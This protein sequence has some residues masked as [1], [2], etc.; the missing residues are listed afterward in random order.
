M[1]WESFSIFFDNYE[2]VYKAFR[3][4]HSCTHDYLLDKRRVRAEA[5]THPAPI[6]QGEE[7]KP[8]TI[9]IGLVCASGKYILLAADTRGSY[10][11]VTS[12][13]QMAKTFDLPANYCG[14]IAGAGDYCADVIAELYHRMSQ[15]P[16]PEIAHEGVR[17]CIRDS[18]HT[19]FMERAEEAML[20]GPKITL[21]QYYHDQ[22]LLPAIRDEA[23]RAIR[24]LEIEGAL[25]VAGFYNGQPVQFI[26][27]PKYPET[28]ALSIRSEITPGN[29][30][31][32][33]GASAATFWLNY[34][35]QNIHLGLAHSLLHLTEAKQFAET[36]QTVGSMRQTI[37]LWPGGH[38]ALNWAPE[39]QSLVQCW[40]HKYGL[41]LSD[42][43]EDESCNKAVRELFAL[44]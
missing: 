20:G 23:E 19:V 17:R 43:L 11:N 2:S 22:N 41:P 34:R 6:T 27:E 29:A 12:N 16:G 39:Y 24:S 40:W 14:L 5:F 35:K 36:E 33:S 31:I 15:L 44:P 9:C 26:A 7:G 4:T 18:Y 10:G 42:G 25:I 37:V 21:D 1:Q 38:K 3:I 8:M 13:E 30:V 32:G 28:T